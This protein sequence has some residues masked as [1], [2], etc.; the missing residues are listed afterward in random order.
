M[1]SETCIETCI[2]LHKQQSVILGACWN[3]SANRGLHKY[4]PQHG[5]GW[6][7]RL[8]FHFLRSFHPAFEVVKLSLDLINP[9]SSG[10]RSWLYSP[11]K[12]RHY[13][14]W[15]GTSS[16]LGRNHKSGASPPS[17]AHLK[18]FP[19]AFAYSPSKHTRQHVSQRD[20]PLRDRLQPRHSRARPRVRIRAVR[21]ITTTST[22]AMVPII[23]SFE[24]G[25]RS[26][27]LPPSC[28]PPPSVFPRRRAP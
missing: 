14:R 9:S 7:W 5:Q 24:F 1:R 27:H 12:H 18:L 10:G 6:F 3:L 21:L 15:E 2:A 20:H 8:P 28:R 13:S 23:G 17:R 4:G 11:T 16:F 22:T 19:Q 26:N 25:L